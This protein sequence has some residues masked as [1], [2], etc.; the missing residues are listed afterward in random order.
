MSKLTTLFLVALLLCFTFSYGVAARP[1]PSLP[2]GSGHQADTQLAAGE[3]EAA[4]HVEV[5][6][7]CEGDGEEECLHRRNL[8]AHLDYIYTQG[9]NKKP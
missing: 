4:E 9:I 3:A 7:S 8:E 5:E 6:E 2:S 1:D